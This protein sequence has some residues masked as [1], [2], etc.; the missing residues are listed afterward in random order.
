MKRIKSIILLII[1]ILS[2]AS[3]YPQSKQDKNFD[4]PFLGV[5]VFIEPGQTQPPVGT[6]L[7]PKGL[8]ELKYFGPNDPGKIVKKI[9][10]TGQ[11]FNEAYQVNTFDLQSGTSGLSANLSQSLKKND[12]LWI[13]FYARSL[14]SKRETGESFIELRIDQ[15]ADGKYVWP[16][17]LERGISFGQEWM[18]TSI[19][20]VITRDVDPKDIRLIIQFDSYPQQFEISPVTFINCGKNVSPDEL[21]RT[22]I[23]YDGGEPDADWRKAAEERIEKYR[24]GNLHIEVKDTKGKPVKGAEITANLR[25]IAF[26]WG[27]ATSSQRLLDTIDINSRVYRDTLTKYFN[28][29]VFE[30]EMKWKVWW[31][32]KKEKKGISALLALRWLRENNINARGHVLVW[33]SWQH[34]PSFLK[35][36]AI[37]TITLRRVIIENIKEQTNYM[38]GQ[39]VEWDVVNE[40]YAHHDVLDILGR[41]EMVEWFKTA[42]IGAPGVRLILND[43]TMFHSEEASRAF[44][45]NIKYLQ[46]EGA[47]IGGIGEQAHIGGTPPGIPKVLERLDKFGELG[48]P[49]VITEFDINSND[50]EFKSRYLRDFMTA[51]FSHPST[52]GFI[53]WGFWEGQHWF[54]VAAL[55]NKDWSLR[56]HGKVF[57]NLV[58]NKWNTRFHG[59][60]PASGSCDVRGFCGQYDIAVHYNGKI[61]NHQTTLQKEG[62]TIIVQI[63]R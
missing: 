61:Y 48:L 24:K 39:F 46:Q 57:T 22:L 41:R 37:D 13:S 4:T 34:S 54:P 63:T 44:Y 8:E 23:K 11:K 28:Q 10:V 7:L 38:Y 56:P 42:H 59:I 26:N 58:S 2:T 31:Q 5:Q 51:V 9:S 12:V 15:L 25:R 35:E 45:E 40:P 62:N 20:L 3:F 52:T 60:T 27:T 30:N 49:I 18:E 17:Y 6:N 50:D 55:W 32:E 21:P 47:P 29:I 14:Q 16:P 36:L 43:Y 19:P 33:P 53:Q 1:C